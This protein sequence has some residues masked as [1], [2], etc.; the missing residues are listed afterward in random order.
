MIFLRLP[1]IR[2]L[3]ITWPAL[4][5]AGLLLVPAVAIA[6]GGASAAP[7]RGT[8]IVGGD[9]AYPPYEFLD[10]NGQ[11]AGYNVELTRAIAAV[12]GMKVQIRL[13]PWGRMRRA[14]AAGRVD[15]L[16]GVAFLDSRLNELDFS[17]PHAIVYQSIWIR[18]GGPTIR[19][20]QDLRGRRVIVMRDSVMD[21]FMRQRH[22]AARLI[23]TDTLADALQELAAGR[24]DC[25]LV[26]KLPGEYLVKSLS[27][28][29]IAPVARPIAEQPYGY[30]VKKGNTALLARFNEG[31]AILKKTGQYQ[32][33]HAKWLGVLEPQG[34]PWDRIL[35]Y[36]AMIVGP[37]LLILGGTVLWSRTLQK[38]VAARTE[39]L[40][41]EVAER[42]RAMEELRIHQ[43]QLIQ[44]DKM[45]SLGILVSGVAH[46]INNPAGL[47]L[48]NLPLLQKAWEDALPLLDAHH[49]ERGDFRLGWLHYSRMRE[50]IPPMLAE[51]Q[52]GARRIRRIVEDLK[53]FA[54]RDDAELGEAVDLN[55]AV[56]AALRLVDNALRKATDNLTVEF[57]EPLPRVHGNQQRIEQVVVNLVLNACQALT[58]KT[59]G[60]LV[61][62][63][64][65]PERGTV[66]LEVRDEGAGIAPENL[67]RLC[68]PFFTTKRETG[69]TGLGLSV[70]TGIV[71]EHGGSLQFRS[72][73]NC[74][75]TV[76]LTLPASKE[77]CA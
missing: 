16:Q 43:R 59:Q 4:L 62:T 27:I 39:A 53:D 11:P 37:L 77:S 21:D 18:K 26:A 22:L 55:S 42:R 25:A 35:R 2:R 7:H 69:G 52:D 54:R 1:N 72:T 34:V 49:R 15:I 71:K 73:P 10:K 57:A 60:I 70:S 31:L 23:P 65:A 13:G 19:S 33:I 45:A 64:P 30:A 48:L 51:M 61:R 29:G 56:R 44:A 58:D 38:E 47:L 5:L 17:T 41:R 76:T 46:E 67:Q 24:G 68:D 6:N 66:V 75:T 8:I 9:R 36:G 32:A 50:E 40:Q 20:V 28:T 63:A 14:L 3:R 12:M 74:G